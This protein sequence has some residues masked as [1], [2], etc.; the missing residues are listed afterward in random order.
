MLLAE[1]SGFQLC[2]LGVL[3]IGTA[4]FLRRLVSKQR[5]IANRN[6]MAEARVTLRA[7]EATNAL[8]LR[9][10]EL[11]LHDFQR[12][13]EGRIETRMAQLDQLILQADEE[14]ERLRSALH[15]S[16]PAEKR[17]EANLGSNDHKHQLYLVQH[18]ADAGYAPEQIAVMVALPTTEVL[19]T[20]GKQS[21][22]RAA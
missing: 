14:I 22:K 3:L 21:D 5:R 19:A 16:Q 20:L 8:N 13:A 6:P 10:L 11:R 18:L 15:E 4:A 17:A 12:E 1:V 9:K 2:L 7:A